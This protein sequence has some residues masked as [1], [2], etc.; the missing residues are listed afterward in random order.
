M[1]LSIWPVIET[2][3][4]RARKQLSGGLTTTERLATL[5]RQSLIEKKDQ[6]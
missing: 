4:G 2:S 1:M 5:P 6:H 3:W